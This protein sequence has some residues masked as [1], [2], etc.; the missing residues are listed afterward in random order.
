[1]METE[2]LTLLC[3]AMGAGTSTLRE[4]EFLTQWDGGYRLIHLSRETMTEMERLTLLSIVM[5]AGTSFLREVEFLI[6]WDGA[7]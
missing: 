4:V 2:R 3:T 7:F 5:A 1:M 6:Q